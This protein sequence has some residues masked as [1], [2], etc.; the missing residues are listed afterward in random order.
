MSTDQQERGNLEVAWHP[1]SLSDRWTWFESV[2]KHKPCGIEGVEIRA[3][4]AVMVGNPTADSLRAR[5]EPHSFVKIAG[6]DPAECMLRIRQGDPLSVR[7]L[8]TRVRNGKNKPAS[9][10]QNS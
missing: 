3:E 7:G 6:D 10:L 1:L 2:L 9:W 8:E 5:G 4:H